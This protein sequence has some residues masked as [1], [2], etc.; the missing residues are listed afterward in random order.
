[1][2]LLNLYY[3]GKSPDYWISI[4]LFNGGFEEVGIVFRVIQL[5]RYLFILFRPDQ[6]YSYKQ[7]AFLDGYHD[8][9]AL[10]IVVRNLPTDLA[11]DRAICYFIILSQQKRFTQYD[12]KP[13]I[14]FER[15][16]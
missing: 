7:S 10:Y 12:R 11:G 6:Y 16:E 8:Y 2:S 1:M 15:D 9:N 4:E 5:I 14:P 13:L 3:S